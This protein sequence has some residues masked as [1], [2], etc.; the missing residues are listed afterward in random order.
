MPASISATS[1][2]WESTAGPRVQTIFERR[3]GRSYR[4]V[5][6]RNIPAGGRYKWAPMCSGV[7]LPCTAVY[8]RVLSRI[9]S[10][11][12]VL[13][14]PWLR[15]SFRSSDVLFDQGV[16]LCRDLQFLVGRY[17]GHGDPCPGRRDQSRLVAPYGIE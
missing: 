1:C 4:F 12:L 17:D 13:L 15:C 5:S 2:S 7:L 9:A 10:Y 6:L 14:S 16:R 11:C 3:M 8:C